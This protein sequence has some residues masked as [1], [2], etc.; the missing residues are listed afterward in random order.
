M[1]AGCPVICAQ[2]PS[3]VDEYLG[4][5]ADSF[6]VGSIDQAVAHALRYVRDPARRAAK[7]HALMDRAETFD[8]SR[9]RPRYAAA[10]EEFLT[11]TEALA[12]QR[13]S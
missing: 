2:F 8:W 6:P 11:R 10:Y 5:R 1:T 13:A 7:S 4:N 3:L 12:D 9:L